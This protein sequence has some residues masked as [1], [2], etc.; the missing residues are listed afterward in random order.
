LTV[1]RSFGTVRHMR[2]AAGCLLLLACSSCHSAS[3]DGARAPTVA[4][5]TESNA[6]SIEVALP[7]DSGNLVSLP[8]ASA[9]ATVIDLWAPSCEPCARSVPALVAKEPELARKGAVP[10]LVAALADQ[11]STD[12]A[13]RALASWGVER[14]FL[15]DRGDAVRAQTGARALPATAVLD[16]SGRLLWLSP[17]AYSAQ[18]VVRALP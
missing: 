17:E 14:S 1:Q 13:R 18:D 8:L 9:R 2:C 6:R 12:L 5:G 3:T 15:I 7:D 4:R 16:A 11:E 10:V